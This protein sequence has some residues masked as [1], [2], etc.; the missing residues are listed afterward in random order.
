[1]SHDHPETP[2]PPKVT[3]L[4]PFAVFP[5]EVQT[6]KGWILWLEVISALAM[7]AGLASMFLIP[8]APPFAKNIMLFGT[9]VL[10]L[11]FGLFTRLETQLTDHALT[12]WFGAGWPKKVIP[13]SEIQ[14]AVAVKNLW[15]YG[16]GLRMIPGGTMWNVFGLDAVELTLHNGKKFRIGT[17]MPESLEQTLQEKLGR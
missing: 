4:N 11:A 9:V 14:S 12:V 8:G 7:L 5:G 15:W 10:V 13:Y 2:Q 6:P 1:M 3:G 16:W 17:Q